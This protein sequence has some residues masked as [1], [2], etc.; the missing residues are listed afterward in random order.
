M[1]TTPK[2]IYVYCIHC[3]GTGKVSLSNGNQDPVVVVCEFCQ[4]AG[5]VLFGE[6][7]EE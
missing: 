3:G 4:G 5:K 6:I 1:A 7:I 2:E